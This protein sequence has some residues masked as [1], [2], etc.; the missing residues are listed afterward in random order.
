MSSAM[1]ARLPPS[2]LCAVTNTR[3]QHTPRGV[4][5]ASPFC[6][7]MPYSHRHRHHPTR[8]PPGEARVLLL[9]LLILYIRAQS[10]RPAAAAAAAGAGEFVFSRPGRPLR[11]RRR[12]ARA[13]KIDRPRTSSL[14][15]SS[16]SC[17][18]PRRSPHPS[19]P[20][21]RSNHV[22]GV[23][24]VPLRPTLGFRFGRFSRPPSPFIHYYYSIYPLR[25]TRHRPFSRIYIISYYP[26]YYYICH[27]RQPAAYNQPDK[28][29]R[30]GF[31]VYGVQSAHIICMFGGVY[32]T[33]YVY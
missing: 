12:G 32:N 6:H 22:S 30:A 10:G 19:Y 21:R 28:M 11:R 26:L 29:S 14:S 31:A 15:S 4:P 8:T 16:P 13:M 18:L 2:P 20:P 3:T 17:Y 25:Y 1:I 24:D 9:L 5:P 27:Q 23:D 33:N 7:P